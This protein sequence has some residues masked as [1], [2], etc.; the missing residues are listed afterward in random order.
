MSEAAWFDEGATPA[1][2]SPFA[3]VVDALCAA[4]ER[5]L[6]SVLFADLVGFTTIAEDRDPESTRDLLTKYFDAA[7]IAA[8]TSGRSTEPPM[9]VK[10][11]RQLMTGSTPIDW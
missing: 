1:S 3:H 6:V 4:N 2:S 11:P 5:R 7:S 8:R 10:V 9:M